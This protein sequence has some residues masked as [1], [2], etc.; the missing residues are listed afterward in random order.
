[1]TVPAD[2]D[3]LADIRALV[4]QVAIEGGAP[5]V[6]LD[7]LVQAVDEAA[8]E[9]GRADVLPNRVVVGERD[10]PHQVDAANRLEVPR[11]VRLGV[12]HPERQPPGIEIAPDE[13]PQL[14]EVLRAVCDRDER[15]TGPKDAGD[16][17][18]AA[19]EVGNVIEHPC[20]DHGVELTVAER[21]LFNVGDEGV[22]AAGTCEVDHSRG[23]I[24]RDDRAAELVAHPLGELAP[25]APDL[26][27][28]PWRQRA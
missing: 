28:A 22:Q 18:K 21:N 9:C 17:G 12:F 8:T 20:R 3:R 14:V 2:L 13:I 16:F 5:P 26:E 19:F 23:Q 24:E 10:R 6:C 1:M 27:Q 15:T 7:D 11:E 4:R 25:P